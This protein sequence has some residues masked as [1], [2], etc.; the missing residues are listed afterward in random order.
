MSKFLGMCLGVVLAAAP[1]LTEAS[2]RDHRG[3]GHQ[4]G[5]SGYYG[6][7]RHH[8]SRHQ[9]R[10]HSRHGNRDY[11]YWD[12]RSYNRSRH[13]RSHH[14]P[15]GHPHGYVKHY[16]QH[17]HHHHRSHRYRAPS[18]YHRPHGYYARSWQRGHYLPTA[19]YA[20]SYYVDYRPYQLAPPPYGHHWVRVGSDVLLVALATGLIADA[21]HGLFY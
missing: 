20:P 19:Y 6:D 17:H 2:P 10:G 8:R 11:G 21:V 7:G 4:H 5:H 3:H 13:D 12:H 1:L 18:H 14:R 9:D 16:G 15:S